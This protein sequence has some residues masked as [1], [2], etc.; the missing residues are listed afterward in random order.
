MNTQQPSIFDQ[1]DDQRDK[2]IKRVMV[3][4]L[5]L[6]SAEALTPAIAGTDSNDLRWTVSLTA[7]F[8]LMLF[9]AYLLVQRKRY[10]GAVYLIAAAVWGT[11]IASVTGFNLLVI[12]L[13]LPIPV[14]IALPFISWRREVALM[15]GTVL[16]GLAIAIRAAPLSDSL[17]NWAIIAGVPF[18]ICLL[19]WYLWFYWVRYNE[20]ITQMQAANTALKQ[21]ERQLE[22]KV[23]ER[24]HE[25]AEARD[26]ALEAT[27]AKSVFLA[28]MSHELRTPMNAIIGYSEMLQEEA[29][30]LGQQGFLNDLQKINTAG[31]HLL[32]LI[33]DILDLS[34]IEAGKMSLYL[35]TFEAAQMVSDVASTVQPLIA[36]NANTL[37]VEC[38]AD[39]GTM[40]ADLT[41]VRQSLFNLLS[42]AA[43]FTERGTI[44]LTASRAAD[45]L[46]WLVFRVSDTGIGI[47]PEHLDNIFQAFTQADS[48]TSRKFGGTGLGLA[49]TQH[50]CRMMGGTIAV[51]S[52]VGQGSTFT[53]RLP[54]SV[55]LQPPPA[56]EP[57]QGVLPK[58][59]LSASS[60][61]TGT[62]LVIDDEP[63]MRDLLQRLLTHEGFQVECASAGEEGLR[64]AKALR[65]DLI[66]LDVLMP[67]MDGWAVLSAMKA[68]AELAVTP[69]IMLTVVDE[70]DLGYALGATEYLTKPIDRAQLK[71]LAERYRRGKQGVGSME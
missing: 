37:R 57:D 35:E 47:T 52:K 39:L 62:V 20:A 22:A 13:V 17:A 64:W 15:A 24:T 46:D 56:V 23:V 27:R 3:V 18:S 41:K 44:T 49:I 7:L 29:Q 1:R 26:Q 61:A 30:A 10:E 43:K 42:N 71:A 32:G 48:S 6:F 9:G 54:A 36:K 67:G 19:F 38:P 14:I 12:V 69:V 55:R 31:K 45:A 59:D 5:L 34:K 21:S 2:L 8:G 65:P 51:T 28:N 4:L 16:T 11:A 70:K 25:L 40:Y 63:A 50:F 58:R 66:L 60:P 53:V 33:N 68:D